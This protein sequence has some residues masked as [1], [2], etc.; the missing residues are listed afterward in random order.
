MNLSKRIR[1]SR[2][3]PGHYEFRSTFDGA[4]PGDVFVWSVFQGDDGDW[5]D[6]PMVED[7]DGNCLGAP[8]FSLSDDD[9]YTRVRDLRAAVESSAV[10][11]RRNELSEGYA[12]RLNG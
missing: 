11:I 1:L 5:N 10:D 12:V 7:A 3:A 9:R 4:R 2:I 8:S 6:H